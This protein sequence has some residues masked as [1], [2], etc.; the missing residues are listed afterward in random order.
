MDGN[1]TLCT[2]I[3][4][5][6]NSCQYSLHHTDPILIGIM[7]DKARSIITCGSNCRRYHLF[8]IV[9]REEYKSAI[10]IPNTESGQRE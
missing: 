10:K 9:S 4:L 1:V 6:L 2:Y 5:L 3:H 7:T 8:S